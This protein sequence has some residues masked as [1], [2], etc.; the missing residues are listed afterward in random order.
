MIGHVPAAQAPTDATHFATSLGE[1]FTVPFLRH[2]L[3]EFLGVFCRKAEGASAIGNGRG[4]W[5]GVINAYRLLSPCFSRGSF[6][7]KR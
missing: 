4:F 6:I 3:V 1:R 5:G 2:D 7:E